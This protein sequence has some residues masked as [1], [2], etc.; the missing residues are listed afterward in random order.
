MEGL[1]NEKK[2]KRKQK[3]YKL[4]RF[5]HYLFIFSARNIL[6]IVIYKF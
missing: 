2:L 6:L 5:A 1:Y 3:K 4:R